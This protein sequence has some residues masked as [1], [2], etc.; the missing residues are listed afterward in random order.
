N[1]KG[2]VKDEIKFN[3]ISPGKNARR[4]KGTAN[5]T[6]F[7]FRSDFYYRYYLGILYLLNV[8]TRNYIEWNTN[9]GDS[10]ILL[11]EKDQVYYRVNDEIYNAPILNGKKLGKAKLLIKDEVVPDIHWAFLSK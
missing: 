9:Q 11:V 4:Q 8:Q 5:G 10:E 7:D 6:P 2:Q 1:E 3:R